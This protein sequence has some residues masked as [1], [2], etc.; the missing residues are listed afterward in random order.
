MFLHSKLLNKMVLKFSVMCSLYVRKINIWY[1]YLFWYY[2]IQKEWYSNNK[3]TIYQAAWKYAVGDWCG[4]DKLAIQQTIAL[5]LTFNT[6]FQTN[7]RH[8][9]TTLFSAVFFW[10][11]WVRGYGWRSNLSFLINFGETY[12]WLLLNLRHNSCSLSSWF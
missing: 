10:G 9:V 2:S 12:L 1:I 11:G 4:V 6:L 5:P 8:H 7:K 3:P